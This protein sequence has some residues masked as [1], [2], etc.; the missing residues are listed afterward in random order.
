[1]AAVH[2]MTINYAHYLLLND[3]RAVST[4]DSCDIIAPLLL[5]QGVAA[6]TSKNGKSGIIV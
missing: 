3:L 2:S 1:M 5:S 6:C 4:E